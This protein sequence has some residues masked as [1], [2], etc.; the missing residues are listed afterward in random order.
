MQ[1]FKIENSGNQFGFEVNFIIM[2]IDSSYS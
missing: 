1:S 2:I